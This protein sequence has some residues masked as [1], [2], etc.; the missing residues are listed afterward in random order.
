M[1]QQ[2]L[3]TKPKK[4]THCEMILDYLKESGDWCNVI[5]IMKDLKPGA[6]NWSVR[7]RISNLREKGYNIESKIDI[8]GQGSYR[9]LGKIK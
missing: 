9:L 4:K 8:N 5:D 7:S 2:D 3:F 1:V 6:I